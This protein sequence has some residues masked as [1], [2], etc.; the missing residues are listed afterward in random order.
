M[1]DQIADAVKIR[2]SEMIIII[3]LVSNCIDWRRCCG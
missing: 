2:I 1:I 3:I